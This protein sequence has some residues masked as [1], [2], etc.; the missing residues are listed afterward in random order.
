LRA[1]RTA[2]NAAKN[3]ADISREALVKSQRAFVGLL[4]WPWLWGPDFDRRGKYFYD[5][6]PVI[7]NTGATPTANMTIVVDY[8]IRDTPLPEGFDFPYRATPG[9][10]LIGPHPTIGSNNAV[11]LD[12][13]LLAMPNGEISFIIVE[14]LDTAMFSMELLSIQQNF[15]LRLLE[16]LVIHWTLVTQL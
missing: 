8:V 9:N 5:I 6:I 10:T 11:I 16:C 7:E 14:L 1:T 15:V 3:A 13:D 2:A 12:D 4:G